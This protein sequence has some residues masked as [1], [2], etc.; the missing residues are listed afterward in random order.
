MF[1][2]GDIVVCIKPYTQPDEQLFHPMPVEGQY[3]TL[4][5]VGIG[6]SI[7]GKR[8]GIRLNE[9]K[10]EMSSNGNEWWMNPERFRKAMSSHD[11]KVIVQSLQESK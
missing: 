4:R 3:Y 5:E 9:C 10:G 1:N 8:P 7:D 11:E 2:V 6:T